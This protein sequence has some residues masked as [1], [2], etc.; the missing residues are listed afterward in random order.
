MVLRFTRRLSKT[1]KL[2]FR[3]GPLEPCQGCSSAFLALAT[4]AR[5][6]PAAGIFPNFHVQICERPAVVEQESA[7]CD[8]LVIQFH[9]I[10]SD[11]LSLVLE[12]LIVTA[13]WTND[14]PWNHILGGG[15]VLEQYDIRAH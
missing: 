7:G 6:S 2:F 14:S 12:D 3:T 4:K 5:D 10:F 15:V 8:N 11:R 9:H 1:V 13:S